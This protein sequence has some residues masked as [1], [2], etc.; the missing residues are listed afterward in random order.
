M[1]CTLAALEAGR[2]SEWRAT[3]LV[4]ETAV[5][6]REDRTRVDAE[7]A[8]D[9]D[10]LERLGDRALAA[11]ARQVAYRL[12][13][14]SVVDR[15]RRAETGRYVTV[16]PAP[17][18]MAY[19]TALLP[20]R[21]AVAV[22]A[23]LGR[24]AEA[25][26]RDGD[27][28]SRGQMMADTLVA[29][30]TRATVGDEAGGGVGDVAGAATEARAA[31]PGA[32]DVDVRLVITD[33]ALLAADDEPATLEGY[34]PVPAGWARDLVASTL[35]EGARVLVRRL[36]TDADGALV[37]MESRA[38]V[39]PRGLASLIRIRDGG[40]CR[41][42]W[43]DAPVRHIDHVVPYARGG[44]TNEADLQGPLR[45]LQPDQGA[46]RMAS[47]GPCRTGAYRRDDDA[48]RAR[49]PVAG[50][51][52]A[53]VRRPHQPRPCGYLRPRLGRRA[54]D[55]LAADAGRLT[56]ATALRGPW[57]LVDQRRHQPR[58]TSWVPA[59]MPART[60]AAPAHSVEVPGPDADLSPRC[61][62]G[63]PP[64]PS[65]GPCAAPSAA[66]RAGPPP[67]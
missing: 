35:D 52:A 57:H 18:T 38:R 40:T 26:R 37:A 25:G 27:P 23:T 21:D 4:R 13:P 34:G 36:F 66:R 50:S 56:P 61:R 60:L 33:R 6:S 54:L 2:I 30:V 41:N 8:G 7:V 24:A 44:P 46:T 48:H 55:G 16:R 47:R 59:G 29:S 20:V 10:S 64:R 28:R 65:S 31:R 53:G 45:S 51:C 63:R 19:L 32:A 1:P 14:R 5:L 49:V 22:Q 17:D 39:A 11:R 12:D 67:P 58:S 43:C 62:P 42:L 3:V 9:V 15:A